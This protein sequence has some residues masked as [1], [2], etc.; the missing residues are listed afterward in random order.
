V[1]VFTSFHHLPSEPSCTIALPIAIYRQPFAH[2]RLRRK[3]FA[4][5][6]AI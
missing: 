3:R 6:K 1:N 5:V 2:Y 4:D